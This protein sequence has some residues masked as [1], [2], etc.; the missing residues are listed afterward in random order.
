M[1]SNKLDLDYKLYIIL[2]WSYRHMYW[3]CNNLLEKDNYNSIYLTYS[4]HCT[5]TNEST[6]SK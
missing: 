3:P 4:T 1:A 5:L 2:L 6:S